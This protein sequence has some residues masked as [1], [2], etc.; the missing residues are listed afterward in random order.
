MW[1]T[2]APKVPTEAHCPSSPPTVNYFSANQVSANKIQKA[3]LNI[4]FPKRQNF[5]W[6]VLRPFTIFHLLEWGATRLVQ[7]LLSR[8]L[9][10]LPGFLFRAPLFARQ[11]HTHWPIWASYAHICP[12]G[13]PKV[14]SCDQ[15]HESPEGARD[16]GIW[17]ARLIIRRAQGPPRALAQAINRSSAQISKASRHINAITAKILGTTSQ[18]GDRQQFPRHLTAANPNFNQPAH[19]ALIFHQASKY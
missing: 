19:K 11:I 4:N 6:F 7:K 1:P 12:R 16:R 9:L 3:H 10:C 8:N 15:P 18:F 13:A 17:A 5:R 14:L 2:E